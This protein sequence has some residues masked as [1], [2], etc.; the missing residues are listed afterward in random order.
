MKRVVIILLTI[1]IVVSVIFTVKI[2]SDIKTKEYRSL[3]WTTIYIIAQSGDEMV[4]YAAGGYRKYL[5]IMKDGDK[6]IKRIEG[7][8]SLVKENM[9]KLKKYPKQYKE[10]YELLLEMYSG[11][12]RIYH[13]YQLEE[14]VS[15]LI[16]NS[17][18]RE[19]G[20]IISKLEIIMPPDTSK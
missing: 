7:N 14:A 2:I 3:F 15:H 8:H 4:S 6:T 17:I 19:A 13:Y 1:T 20:E 5:V 12:N 16:L 11:Y 10:A 9:I 18:I